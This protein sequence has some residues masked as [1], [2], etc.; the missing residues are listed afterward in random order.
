MASFTCPV[1]GWLLARVSLCPPPLA[2]YPLAHYDQPVKRQFWVFRCSKGASTS[3]FKPLLYL[4]SAYVP[5]GSSCGQMIQ[6]VEKSN[7]SY[8]R[9]HIATG[10]W[11]VWC[12]FY[13]L[14]QLWRLQI[15][16]KKERGVK[17]GR[18][19]M[20]FVYFKAFP[21]IAPSLGQAPL[22]SKEKSGRCGS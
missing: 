17:K 12:S 18:V 9:L 19:K 13:H 11:G 15:W 8:G 20:I 5:V 10:W 6:R 4:L 1:V 21:G 14:L 22:C 2:S 7:L 16:R 3:T